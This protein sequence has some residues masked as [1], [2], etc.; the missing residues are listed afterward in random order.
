MLISAR[1]CARR[2]GYYESCGCHC[3]TEDEGENEGV[4]YSSWGE[5]EIRARATHVSQSAV[6]Y[7]AHA[8]LLRGYAVETGQGHAWVTGVNG[9]VSRFVE[10][11]AAK[12]SVAHLL[13]G[14]RDTGAR[15]SM[16][17]GHAPLVYYNNTKPT[18]W[19]AAAPD[20][21]RVAA[22]NTDPN[23]AAGLS[24]WADVCASW[25]VRRFEDESE[26][27]EVDM[28]VAY[29]VASVGRCS[30]YAY[31]DTDAASTHAGKNSHAAPDDLR[32][33]EW[34]HSYAPVPANQPNNTHVFAMKKD[35][36]EGLWIPRLQSTLYY[37][38][39]WQREVDAAIGA[40]TNAPALA[41]KVHLFYSTLTAAACM[42]LCA[43]EAVANVRTVRSVRFD[44]VARNCY[45][46]DDSLFQWTFDSFDDQ[47]NALWLLD[48]DTQ[49]EWYEVTFCEFVRPDSTGRALI[50]SKNLNPPGQADGWCSGSP[51]GAG[52][53]SARHTR[54]L[55]PQFSTSRRCL[56]QDT[57]FNPEA[58]S[59]ATRRGRARRCAPKRLSQPRSRGRP[60]TMPVRHAPQPFDILCKEKCEER[61]DCQ[62]A[63]VFLETFS[64]IASAHAKP[65]AY[66]R[67]LTLRAVHST[68]RS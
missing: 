63:H 6:L 11:D 7:A 39:L 37:H 62:S 36:G 51:A 44:P 29:G 48:P 4:A 50:W 9:G 13:S 18:W 40:L 56:S 38:R 53:R 33:L 25:C 32:A 14:Y 59:T 68:T 1:C 28:T 64:S 2:P 66:S 46:F 10:S 45:C 35:V 49:A 55:A 26:F 19:P 23:T 16:R 3:F 47:N 21:W 42:E 34:L 67:S 43:A 12:A 61:S 58:C 41:G 54:P 20:Q 30:C 31:Q 57:S 15:A 27:M 17:L 52:A 60:L 24:F 65:Y 8:T 22:N 5:I